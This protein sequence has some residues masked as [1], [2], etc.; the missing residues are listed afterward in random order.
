MVW[1][2]SNRRNGRTDS[3]CSNRCCLGLWQVLLA[4]TGRRAS[5]AWCRQAWAS[6]HTSEYRW[7]VGGWVGEGI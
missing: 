1:A 4:W 3:G 5:R 2:G 6:T 7:Q